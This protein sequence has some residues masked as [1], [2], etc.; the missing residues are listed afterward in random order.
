M[1]PT[2]IR[3][4]ALARIK[5]IHKISQDYNSQLNH[6]HTEKLLTLIQEH[7]EEIR[8]LYTKKDS[9]YLTETGDLIILCFELL[10]E[11]QASINETLLKCFKRYE[12]KLPRLLQEALES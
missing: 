8:D 10:L 4:S 9:H 5:D 3:D 12:T 1:S 7:S 2:A 11:N 6:N